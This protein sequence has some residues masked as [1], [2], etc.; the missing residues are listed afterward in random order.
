M[1]ENI[2]KYHLQTAWPIEA[3]ATIIAL[4]LSRRHRCHRN[5]LHW[6]THN[7]GACSNWGMDLR[8]W[9]SSRWYL[10]A[11]RIVTPGVI[12][13]AASRIGPMKMR[14]RSRSGRQGVRG[15]GASGEVIVGR[16]WGHSTLELSVIRW[17]WPVM[18]WR[19]KGVWWWWMIYSISVSIRVNGCRKIRWRP[20]RWRMAS[21]IS[22]EW[23]LRRK[24]WILLAQS[25]LFNL[26]W[27]AGM[28][29]RP[30]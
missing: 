1:G 27:V 28:P 26:T 12:K 11:S 15:C 8:F 29:G 16:V 9:K 19:G 22:R 23:A 25:V 2:L 7:V 4:V 10:L 21:R 24:G 6:V 14:R 20:H 5:F 3:F 13:I 18:T 30:A 17:S